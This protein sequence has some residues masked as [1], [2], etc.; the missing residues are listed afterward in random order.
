MLLA[1]SGTVKAKLLVSAQASILAPPQCSPV[2]IFSNTPSAI[3]SA[4]DP[5]RNDC[6]GV[7]RWWSPLN[8]G[9]NHENREVVGLSKIY[10]SVKSGNPRTP[11]TR[12]RC[13][14]LRR[15]LRQYNGVDCGSLGRG[16]IRRPALRQ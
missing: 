12:C 5:W 10:G 16:Q 6:L 1:G 8:E 15:R 7:G 9:K 2:V 3:P 14:S 11:I 4:D 13:L